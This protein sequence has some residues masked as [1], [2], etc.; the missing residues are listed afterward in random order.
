ME[1]EKELLIKHLE[2]IQTVINRQASNSFL[3]KGW[4][5]TLVASL[6]ALSN[7]DLGSS[8]A[9]IAFLPTTVF[10][11]LDGYY[12]T[13]ERRFRDLYDD[14]RKGNKT[15]FSMNLDSIGFSDIFSSVWSSSIWPFYITLIAA[16]LLV[17]KLLN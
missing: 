3:L 1:K 17:S 12:L 14:T 13:Q 8:Y 4:A 16:I 10:W 5:V 11:V 9:I 6:L 15:N 7:R 2:L